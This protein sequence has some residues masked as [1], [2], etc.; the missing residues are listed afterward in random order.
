MEF[1]RGTIDAKGV[2]RAGLQ[3]GTPI[4]T[5]PSWRKARTHVRRS[6]NPR[7]FLVV[8]VIDKKVLNL[9]V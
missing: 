9:E 3:E 2:F 7:S 4:Y 6:L 5:K 8:Q 1:Y